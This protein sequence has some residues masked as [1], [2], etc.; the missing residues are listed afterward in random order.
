M[1]SQDVTITHEGYFDKKGTVL[2]KTKKEKEASIEWLLFEKCMR[3]DT[4]DNVFSAYPGVRVKGTKNKVGLQEAFADKESKGYSWN[5]LML[6]RWVDHD[7]KEH[8]VLEDYQRNVIL[9]DLT[10]QPDNIRT[11]I[12][13]TIYCYTNTK[14]VQQVGIKLMKFCAR[15]ELNKISEQ[16]Q[17]YSEPLN[18]RYVCN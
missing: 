1:V 3:G 12:N 11:I 5:N 2:D 10:A 17:S 18:A 14:E 9:C 15:H 8:R 13:D 16:V 6:Q 4:S 7:G